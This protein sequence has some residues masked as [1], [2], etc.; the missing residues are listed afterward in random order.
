M[1]RTPKGPARLGSHAAAEPKHWGWTP[2][3]A[4]S[5]AVVAPR[6]ASRSRQ[7]AGTASSVGFVGLGDAVGCRL[8]R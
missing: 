1:S 8:D 7:V 2:T 5:S 6:P 4:G 3:T